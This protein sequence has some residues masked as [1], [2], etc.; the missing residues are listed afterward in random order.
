M[1]KR[2]KKVTIA[3]VL[4][5]IAIYFLAV[6]PTRS[7]L[8]QRQQVRSTV[9]KVKAMEASNQ[10]LQKQ[11]NA[12]NSPSEIASIARSEYGLIKPGEKAFVVLPPSKSTTTTT[13]QVK[14]SKK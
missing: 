11:V 5:G 12:M 1:K 10:A 14:S 13:T 3:F 7:F 6:F 2:R 9:A 4:V 8:L